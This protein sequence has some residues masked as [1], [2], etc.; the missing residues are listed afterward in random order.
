MPKEIYYLFITRLYV[1]AV[2]VNEGNEQAAP[3]VGKESLNVNHHDID[4][5]QGYTLS[6]SFQ[7]YF[8][9]TCRRQRRARCL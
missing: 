3:T 1:Y 8:S 7:R 5:Y 2:N 4:S 6:F 9:F